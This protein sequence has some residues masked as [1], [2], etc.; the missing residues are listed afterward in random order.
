[1]IEFLFTVVLIL[2]GTNLFAF[3]APFLQVSIGNVSII[4]L[5][6]NISYLLFRF[7]LTS[8]ILLQRNMW[9]FTFIFVIWPFLT[10]FYS[11]IL[12]IR[13]IGLRIYTFTLF[14]CTNVFII[15]N[16]FTKFNRII[17]INFSLIILGLVLSMVKPEYFQS[18]AELIGKRNDA[19]GRP[20]GF[21]MEPNVQGH[22]IIYTFI[23]YFALFKHK[24]TIFFIGS[25][26]SFLLLM[27]ITGSRSGVIV[28]VIVFSLILFNSSKQHSHNNQPL[29]R[30]TLLFIFM[31]FCLACLKVYLSGIE[32]SVIRR[33]DDLIDRMNSMLSFGLNKNDGLQGDM[34]LYGRTEA[35]LFYLSFIKEKPFLGYG[36]GSH[37][38]YYESGI[39]FRTAHSEAVIRAFEYGIFY[40]LFFVVLILQIFRSKNRKIVETCFQTNSIAQFTLSAILLFIVNGDLLDNRP[41]YII[42]AMFYTAI[43][44]P[45]A[46]LTYTNRHPKSI[47]IINTELIPFSTPPIQTE[48]V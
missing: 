5:F 23:A 20:F 37:A 39:F 44:N 30:I 27:L 9:N 38:L 41:F 28:S 47:S 16:G 40:P 15:R 19:M 18:M 24:N 22:V 48:K 32:Q 42:L 7:K 2:N 12:E 6:I 14:V 31:F 4:L 3:I 45:M 34:S 8:Q 29:V 10:I 1:M 13:E 46:I 25:L 26:L 35:Q 43:N 33:D 21:F 11:P 36:F 17:S